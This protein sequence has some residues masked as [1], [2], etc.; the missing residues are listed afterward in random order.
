MV[1]FI[2]YGRNV[3]KDVP[4]PGQKQTQKYISLLVLFGVVM[5]ITQNPFSWPPSIINYAMFLQ[6]FLCIIFIYFSLK[7]KI[8]SNI[9]HI[10]MQIHRKSSI[11]Y[12]SISFPRKS[13][14]TI[15]CICRD[16][17]RLH[18]RTF[19]YSSNNIEWYST[20]PIFY[21]LEQH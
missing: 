1:L 18:V 9:T 3:P 2:I 10:Q 5:F 15:Y 4:D 21:L 11:G 14:Q 16:R 17:K 13:W 6:I 12:L 7:C 8:N 20:S 19:D